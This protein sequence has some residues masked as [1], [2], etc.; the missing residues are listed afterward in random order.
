MGNDE[1]AEEKLAEMPDDHDV[2]IGKPDENEAGAAAEKPKKRFSLLKLLYDIISTLLFLVFLAVLFYLVS[3]R[4]AHGISIGPYRILNVLTGS[5]EPTIHT[6]SMIIIKETTYSNLSVGDI[7]TYIPANEETVLLTHR[8]VSKN[9]ED[10]TFMTRGDANDTDDDFPVA[11]DRVVGEFVYAIPVLGALTAYLR[12]LPGII[13]A[14]ILCL[15]II[16]V[17]KLLR[18]AFKALHNA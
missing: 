13:S 12:T 4:D 18:F 2:H 3:G 15:A 9:P 17:P 16:L 14:V 5:M 10:R 11:F 6:G 8:I 7:V 1:K